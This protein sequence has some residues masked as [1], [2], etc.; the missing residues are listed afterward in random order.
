MELRYYSADERKLL[1]ILAVAVMAGTVYIGLPGRYFIEC[2]ALFIIYD[3]PIV[4][5][6][7][8]L[9][10]SILGYDFY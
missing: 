5:S 6:H 3:S 4:S 10:S 9:D 1:L 8:F 7:S 2:E